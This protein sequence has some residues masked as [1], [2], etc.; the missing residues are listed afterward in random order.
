MADDGYQ[1]DLPAMA[2]HA[3]DLANAADH[4]R[5]A[6]AA[7]AAVQLDTGA[8][9]HLLLWLPPVMSYLQDT[10]ISTLR[11]G[12]QAVRESADDVSRAARGYAETDHHAAQS[13][14][15]GWLR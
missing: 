10:V 1:V 11:D 7:A 5:N 15:D 12:E 3:G 6:R 14:R 2:A 4:I 9:G 8:Y 13:Y